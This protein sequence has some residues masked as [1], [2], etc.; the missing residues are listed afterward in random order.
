MA[1][2]FHFSGKLFQKGQMAEA[3][4]AICRLDIRGFDY[5]RAQKP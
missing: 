3:A 4:L 5:S 1:K 2:S